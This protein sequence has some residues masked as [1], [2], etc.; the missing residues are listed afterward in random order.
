[1][2]NSLD[3]D[4]DDDDEIMLLYLKQLDQ[5]FPSTI[6]ILL[7]TISL[8]TMQIVF[9]NTKDKISWIEKL[10]LTKCYCYNSH[11]N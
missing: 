8:I 1:M 3:D 10:I 2:L 7:I 6:T 9:D 11:L 4:D 5:L